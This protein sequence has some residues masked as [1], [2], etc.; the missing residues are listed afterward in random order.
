[1]PALSSDSGP[2]TSLVRLPDLSVPVGCSQYICVPQTQQVVVTVAPRRKDH[3]SSE[4]VDT[5]T[6]R[7]L[8][9]SAV[10]FPQAL[11]GA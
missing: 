7:G 11:N 9:R 8:G 6:A 3:D 4:E 1:M 10:L 2:S 5:G